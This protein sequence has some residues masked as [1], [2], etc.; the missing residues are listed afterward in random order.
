MRLDGDRV[1]EKV[2]QPDNA[3]RVLAA[4]DSETERQEL[5][6]PA[7][8]ESK[9]E[10]DEPEADAATSERTP[11]EQGD[12]APEPPTPS[13]EEGEDE[14]REPLDRINL[15]DYAGTML[16]LREGE[17]VRGTVVQIDAD[18][19]MVDVRTKS[20]GLIPRAEVEALGEDEL[21]VGQEIDVYVVRIEDEEGNLIV[22]KR[23]ADY[24]RSWQDIIEAEKEGRTMEATVEDAVR[25]GLIVN[26]GAY[27]QGFVPASHTSLKRPKNLN[28]FVGQTLPLKVIEVDR[29]RKRVVLSHRL[30]LEEERKRSKETTLASLAEGQIREGI[31]RRLTDFGAFVDL[32]G[33]D[34]LLHVSEMSWTRVN[35]PSEVLKV[36]DKIQV[37]VLK[38]NLEENRIS[39]GRR[40]LLPDPWKEVS[41]L[42]REGQILRGRITRTGPFGAFVQMPNGVEGLVQMSEL[43]DRR[44]NNAEDV[45]KVGDEIDVK[46]LQIRAHERRMALSKRQAD[47]Q[48]MEDRTRAEYSE[49]VE[50]QQQTAGRRP[51]LRDVFGDLLKQREEPAEEQEPSA[52]TDSSTTETETDAP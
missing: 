36:G 19:A 2:L 10:W 17:I 50:Q 39:L 6:S 33:V 23:Q 18:G 28:R 22:S 20:E 4:T 30:V 38:L 27:G 48:T 12:T 21:K 13:P 43:S 34:G 25:G 3:L 49:Y 37:M 45:V 47:Q 7:V 46:V 1:V 51:T 14:E 41:R 52:E 24:E 16:E 29:K 26:L 35:H 11:E 40:Q 42:Y 31:V 15:D 44:V 5:S 32:G 8:A 9:K